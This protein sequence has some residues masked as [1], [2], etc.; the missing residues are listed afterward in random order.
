[1]GPACE[2][3]VAD[4]DAKTRAMTADVAATTRPVLLLL[5]KAPFGID[6]AASPQRRE[7][8]GACN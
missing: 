6:E 5:I 4:A 2:G 7:F 3:L 1:M 8:K